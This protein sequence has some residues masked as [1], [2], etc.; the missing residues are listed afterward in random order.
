MK[1]LF[2]H[3]LPVCAGLI[4]A[5]SATGSQNVARV[6]SQN[7]SL[8]EFTNAVR[9]E[10]EKYDGSSAISPEKIEQIKKAVLENLIRDRVLEA[11]AKRLGIT[12]SEEE[13]NDQYVRNKSH[14]TETTF[15]KMLEIKGISYDLWKADKKRELL[16]EK[17]IDSEVANKIEINDKDVE[18]YYKIH[19]KEFSHGDEV[20]ARQIVVEDQK[21]AETVWQKAKS[22]DNFA[23]LAQ[24][25]SIAPEAKRGGDLGWFER[26]IMPKIFDEACFPLPTNEISPIVKTE[27]GYHIFKVV[28]RRPAAAKPLAEVKETIVNKLRQERIQD[29]YE[30]WYEPLRKKA[31]VEI[32]KKV[33]DTVTDPV[34]ATNVRTETK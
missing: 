27:F 18:R 6:G 17:L 20:H 34:A 25:F 31:K 2:L 3:F 29:A 9:F 30:K 19:K 33:F 28:E 16:I 12:A 24:E 1:R 7:I 15:Q 13:I 11:E 10:V 14:Y 4:V 23:A 21:T 32:D 8:D 26:G 5:C 22:D